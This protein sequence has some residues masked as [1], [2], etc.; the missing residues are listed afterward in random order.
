MAE[1][2]PRMSR[3]LAATLKLIEL[4][5]DRALVWGALSRE[6]ITV[7]EEREGK[8]VSAGYQTEYGGHEVI[9]YTVTEEVEYIEGRDGRRTKASEWNQYRLNLPHLLTA[10]ARV[11]VPE[12]IVKL[13]LNSNG[14]MSDFPTNTGLPDLL[15]AVENQLT[16]ANDFIDKLLQ[17]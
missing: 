10:A 2:K 7:L 11:L 5:Q 1:L 9:L 17:E 16:V 12:R 14:T 8:S 3:P 6:K 15:A 4:T 13:V